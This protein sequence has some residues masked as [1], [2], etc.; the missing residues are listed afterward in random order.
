[1][2]YLALACDYDGTLAHHGVVDEAVIEALVCFRESRR[3]LLMVTGREL[4]DL[5]RTFDR[6][7]LFDL[8]VVENGAVLY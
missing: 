3:R 8:A 6:L 2:H 7:D 4:P 5:K 1:M